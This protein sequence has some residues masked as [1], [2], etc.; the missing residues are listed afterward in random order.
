MLFLKSCELPESEASDSS[1]EYGSPNLRGHYDDD[2]EP[3]LEVHHR[4]RVSSTVYKC[5]LE[6]CKPIAIKKLH[7]HNPH[8]LKEFETE[9]GIV[10]NIKHRNLVSLQ[11]YLFF[12]LNFCYNKCPS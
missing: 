5:L 12:S 7:S 6:N 2:G 11:D 4:C 8:A 1:Q 10:T 9:V 3:K